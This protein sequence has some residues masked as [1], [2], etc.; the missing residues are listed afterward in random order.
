MPDGGRVREGASDEEQLPMGI[1]G[2]IPAYHG[3][4]IEQ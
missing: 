3:L 2:P 4:F 1:S